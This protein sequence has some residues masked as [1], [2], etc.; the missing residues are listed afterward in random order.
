MHDFFDYIW[1]TILV[2]KLIQIYNKKSIS[3]KFTMTET[4]V[5]V[6]KEIV[7]KLFQS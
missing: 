5:A 7:N 2:I 6:L 4:L 3:R 1:L